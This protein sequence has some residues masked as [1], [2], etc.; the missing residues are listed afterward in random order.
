VGSAPLASPSTGEPPVP[1]GK[2]WM[3]FELR[4]G[5][6]M[7]AMPWRWGKIEIGDG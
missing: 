3:C 1:V 7:A 2:V 4:L 5:T 6:V